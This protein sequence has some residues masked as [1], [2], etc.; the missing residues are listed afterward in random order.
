MIKPIPFDSAETSESL[1]RL[2]KSFLVDI[3]GM[4]Q[5]EVDK[6]KPFTCSRLLTNKPPV[7]RF[8]DVIFSTTSDRDTVMARSGG[9]FVA[10]GAERKGSMFMKVPK[11]WSQLRNNL[12]RDV[13][14]LRSI[15]TAA[16]LQAFHAQVRFDDYVS[17]P[18]WRSS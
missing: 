15:K 10:G 8:V 13:Q 5:W 12:E 6:L 18:R 9:L 3:V 1:S 17:P 7:D 16:G 14:T 11:S 2:V 4:E